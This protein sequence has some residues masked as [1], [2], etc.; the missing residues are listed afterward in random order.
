MDMHEIV[1]GQGLDEIEMHTSIYHYHY[2]PK[3]QTSTVYS[4]SE[5]KL[6]KSCQN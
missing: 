2:I 1:H 4:S 5:R 3:V 6:D